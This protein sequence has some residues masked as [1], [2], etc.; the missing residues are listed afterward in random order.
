MK[1]KFSLKCKHAAAT[2]QTVV[3]H[4]KKYIFS[5]YAYASCGTFIIYYSKMN[6][7]T[8]KRKMKFGCMPDFDNIYIRFNSEHHIRR[9]CEIIWADFHLITQFFSYADHYEFNKYY[10]TD[11]T[12]VANRTNRPEMKKTTTTKQIIGTSVK[13]IVKSKKINGS[14]YLLIHIWY[15]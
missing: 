13:K 15:Y 1:C 2:T 8:L 11:K 12:L 7:K 10:K 5:P 14:S 9:E 3:A 6:G 4:W